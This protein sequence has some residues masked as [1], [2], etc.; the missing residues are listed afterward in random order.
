MQQQSI[1]ISHVGFYLNDGDIIAINHIDTN[2]A[3][4]IDSPQYKNCGTFKLIIN[5]AHNI[6]IDEKIVY[7]KITMLG[8]Y[9]QLLNVSVIGNKIELLIEWSRYDKVAIHFMKFYEIE[10]DNLII[11]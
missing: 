5:G 9:G 6:K 2:I 10:F 8:N 11:K 4:D 7:D 1:D 3:L